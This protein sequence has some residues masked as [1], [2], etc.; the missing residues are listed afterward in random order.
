MHAPIYIYIYI[1]IYINYI[2]IYII[3]AKNYAGII[4]G[5]YILVL[6]T[7]CLHT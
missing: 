2:Y 3:Y 7:V 6:K 1:Y 4:G 5:G